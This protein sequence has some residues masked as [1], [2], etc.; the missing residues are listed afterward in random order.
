MENIM[1]I[2]ELG[3][4]AP[5]CFVAALLIR[6]HRSGILQYVAELVNAAEVAIQGSGMGAEK[7]A[8]VLAQLEAAGIRINTWLSVAIDKM[9]QHLNESGAWL[10][11]QAREHAAGLEHSDDVPESDTEEGQAV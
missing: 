2:V 6:Y 4:L 5:G 1:Q 3:L 11:S 9:V 8:L 7:K 10:A